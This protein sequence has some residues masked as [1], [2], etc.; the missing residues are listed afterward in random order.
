[1]YDLTHTCVS[2]YN[3]PF[4][5]VHAAYTAYVSFENRDGK[6]ATKI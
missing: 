1:M 2:F 3:F 4:Y 5:F 6:F